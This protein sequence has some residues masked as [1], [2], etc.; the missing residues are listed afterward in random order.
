MVLLVEGAGV[1]E[2]G[3]AS[4]E[5]VVVSRAAVGATKEDEEDTKEG[6]HPTKDVEACKPAGEEEDSEEDVEETSSRI[7]TNPWRNRTGAR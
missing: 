4:R 1:S 2:V 7:T 3:E 5:V 6:E